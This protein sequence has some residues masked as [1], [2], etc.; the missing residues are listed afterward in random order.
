MNYEGCGEEE[1]SAWSDIRNAVRAAGLPTTP[2]CS[3]DEEQEQEQHEA[4]GMSVPGGFLGAAMFGIAA[5][6]VIAA[7]EQGAA[8]GRDGGYS[9]GGGGGG[10]GGSGGDVYGGGSV[11]RYDTFAQKSAAA[12]WREERARQAFD[13]LRTEVEPAGI[14]AHR[15]L[16][17]PNCHLTAPCY[18]SFSKYVKAHAGWTVRRRTATEAEKQAHG[19]RRLGKCYFINVTYHPP[20]CPAYSQA[21]RE[22]GQ[23]ANIFPPLPP[24]PPLAAKRQTYHTEGMSSARNVRPRV[25]DDNMARASA[26]NG[27]HGACRGLHWVSGGGGCQNEACRGLAK[28]V[29]SCRGCPDAVPLLGVCQGTHSVSGGC[30]NEACR[31]RDKCVASCRGCPDRPENRPAG[32]TVM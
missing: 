14:S 23:P 16:L 30:K 25:G 12:M 19:E 17:R 8:F 6:T 20:A 24:L 32:C 18:R 3:D 11:L 21:G 31:R 4:H 28:C 15:E 13:L 29:A 1:G 10:W 7:G 2:P 5:A 9:G 27:F 26:E 22:Q